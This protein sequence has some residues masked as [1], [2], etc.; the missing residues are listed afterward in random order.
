MSQAHL[1]RHQLKQRRTAVGILICLIG[2][3]ASS[4][5]PLNGVQYH[6]RI[7][8]SGG[9]IPLHDF[10]F[11]N[12]SGG[13]DVEWFASTDAP[14]IG[15]LVSEYWEITPNPF[16]FHSLRLL[17]EWRA[18]K[19]PNNTTIHIFIPLWIPPIT[20]GLWSWFW[21]SRTNRKGIDTAGKKGDLRQRP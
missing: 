20:W 10:S 3:Y 5:F 13:L 1:Q 18:L 16:D 15:Y 6:R 21:I 2:L 11:F 19:Y 14:P 12:Q 9:S 17:P 8:L 4:F 7:R